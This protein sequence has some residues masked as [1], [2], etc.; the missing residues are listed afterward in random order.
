MGIQSG[1]LLPLGTLQVQTSMMSVAGG[2]SVSSPG[3]SHSSGLLFDD[4]SGCRQTRH[5]CIELVEEKH[6]A[7]IKNRNQRYVA[8]KKGNTQK[9]AGLDFM[10]S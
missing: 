7:Q 6:G 1:C 3:E 10:L 4:R 2:D 5:S 9:N 8:P